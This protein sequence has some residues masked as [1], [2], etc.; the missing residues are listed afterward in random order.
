MLTSNPG[1]VEVKMNSSVREYLR[2]VTVNYAKDNPMLSGQAVY[3]YMLRH[4][5]NATEK[6]VSLAQIRKWVKESRQGCP[7]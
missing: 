2:G 3:D 6:F 4:Y 7:E 5:S 1:Q